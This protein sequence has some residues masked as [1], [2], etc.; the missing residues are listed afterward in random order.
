[1]QGEAVVLCRS[2]QPLFDS[3]RVLIE[4]GVGP[5]D[6]I[7][8]VPEATPDV[9][10]MHRRL[11]LRRSSTKGDRFHLRQKAS[12]GLIAAAPMR[13]SG[14]S[15][16]LGRQTHPR[17][18]V[19]MRDTA[20]RDRLTLFAEMIETQTA[21]DLVNDAGVFIQPPPGRG[22]RMIDAHR[23]RHTQWRGRR[24]MVRVWKGQRK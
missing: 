23:E 15:L 2:H 20:R 13:F 1:L 10:A 4:R 11:A 7:A 22:W 14:A 18:G 3:A 24:P 16:R 5:A 17:R 19:A 8:M 12:A 9:I 21:R 6:T